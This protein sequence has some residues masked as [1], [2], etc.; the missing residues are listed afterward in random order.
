[1][2]SG[3]FF[4]REQVGALGTQLPLAPFRDVFVLGPLPDSPATDFE[5]PGQFGVGGEPQGVLDRGFRHLHGEQS[6]TLDPGSVKHS[7][8][9]GEYGS[10]PMD[11]LADRLQR[12]L[13]LRGLKPADLADRRVMSRAGVYFIL[14]GTTKADKIREDTVTKL[15]RAL[16]VNREWLLHGRGPIEGDGD[17]RDPEWSDVLGYSQAV[18]LG[19]GAEAQEYA[20]THKLKFK[21]SSFAKKRLRP[22]KLAV[23]YGQGDS[24]EP[25]IRA[26]DAIMFDTSDTTP[27]D[28]N[29]FVVQWKGEYFAKRCEIID[30]MV[31][32]KSDNPNGDH[33]WH[34]PKRADAKRDPVQ[35]LGRVR[36][37]GSWED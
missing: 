23:F 8:Q 27:R 31:F 22:D 6:R 21:A 18:G 9:L 25:R 13:H 28:G 10:S 5:E 36:W 3:G 7:S 24:M 37:I 30:D 17:R 29:I 33:Q 11:N 35:I 20:E 1:M 14:N 2:E 26:G 12:A 34:K 15:C 32:F 16:G 19:S 4:G